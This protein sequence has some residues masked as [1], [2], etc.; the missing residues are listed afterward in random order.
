MI[1]QYCQQSCVQDPR[2]FSDNIVFWVCPNC[3]PRVVYFHVKETDPLIYTMEIE[4]SHN[5]KLLFYK[6]IRPMKKDTI[7]PPSVAAFYW[8]AEKLFSM[9]IPNNVTPGTVEEKFAIYAT[10]L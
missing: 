5:G 9:P 7:H 10:F 2:S 4:F 3:K 6:E 8:G 1:C